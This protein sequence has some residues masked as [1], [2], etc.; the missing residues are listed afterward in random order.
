MK[1]KAIIAFILFAA[2]LLPALSL[3]DGVIL[4]ANEDVPVSSLTEYDVKQIFL[5]N[6]TTWEDGPKIVFA[7]QDE[8]DAGKVFLKTY[9]RKSESQY[10]NYWKKRVFT[11]KGKKPAS[12]SSDDEVIDFVTQTSGA[13]GYV[14]SGAATGDAKPLSIQ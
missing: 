10:K 7:I 12:F 13:V 9:V 2:L 8:T 5:G 3:A 6:K 14:T 1:P 11:G 4:V